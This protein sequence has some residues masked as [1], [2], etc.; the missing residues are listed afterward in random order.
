M[1]RI[2]LDAA[3]WQDRAD[4]YRAILAALEAPTWHGANLDALLDGLR[5]GVNGVEAPFTLTI[6]R[7][8]ASLA[9]FGAGLA[10]VFTQAQ[11]EG[12]EV[13]LVLRG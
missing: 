1:R 11:S 8:P 13:A 4:G 2:T 5:G 6:N 10:E 3:R 9:G 12:V 7:L